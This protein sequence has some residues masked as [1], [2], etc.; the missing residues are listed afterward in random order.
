MFVHA[1]HMLNTNDI[2]YHIKKMKKLQMSRENDIKD[3]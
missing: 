1:L 2:T 3:S